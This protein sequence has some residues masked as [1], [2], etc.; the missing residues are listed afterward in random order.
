MQARRFACKPP[1]MQACDEYHV[2]SAAAVTIFL[3]WRWL[4]FF[5]R[6]KAGGDGLT[7]EGVTAYTLMSISTRLENSSTGLDLTRKLD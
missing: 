1:L 6:H 3:I 7:R 4:L 5:D 2:N